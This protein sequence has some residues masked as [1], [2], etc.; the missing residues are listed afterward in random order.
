MKQEKK[1]N[2]IIWFIHDNIKFRVKN[3]DKKTSVIWISSNFKN[4]CL[5]LMIN[6]FFTYCE[7][8]LGIIIEIDRNWNK[9]RG[10]ILNKN[11]V[12]LILGEIIN[13]IIEWEIEPNPNADEF[14]KKEWYSQ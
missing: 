12:D 4:I 2:N 9:H 3:T 5:T 1:E 13:F 8:N 6:E 11:E 14:S 7:E 10:L